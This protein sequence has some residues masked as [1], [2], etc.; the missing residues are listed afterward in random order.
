M[1]ISLKHQQKNYKF[2]LNQPIDISLLLSADQPQVNCFYAPHFEIKPL[3]AGDFV[4]SIKAGAP[5]NFM[6]VHINPHGNG[7]HTECLSHIFDVPLT[8]NQALQK[9]H[10]LAQLITIDI[11]SSNC[12]KLED[13]KN[14]QFN[15]PALIIRT[16][17]NPTD[18]KNKNYSGNN[19]PFIEESAMQY[20]V[21]QGVEHLLVDIPSVDPEVDGGKLLAHKA[22][23]QVPKNPRTNCTITELIYVP[24]KVTDGI[25][26][27]NIQIINIEMDASPSKI[28]LYEI[29][30]N[31]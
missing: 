20:I 6:N 13:L 16:Q 18:K 31:D 3:I 9:F 22:F 12:I 7:T 14:H 29:I 10:F 24:N 4:G 28:L 21:S 26:L 23:W 11:S 15:F 17:P 19:P 8:I 25:Y 1:E 2:N 30:D 5:V 27:V